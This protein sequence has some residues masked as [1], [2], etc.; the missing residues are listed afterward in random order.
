MSKHIHI[1]LVLLCLASGVQAQETPTDDGCMPPLEKLSTN[2]QHEWNDFLNAIC[3]D[4]KKQGPSGN[5]PALTF[6][7][8]NSERIVVGADYNLDDSAAS[9]A[10]EQYDWMRVMVMYDATKRLGDIFNTVANLGYH[11]VIHATFQPG[12][13][14]Q[15]YVY[16]NATLRHIMSLESPMSA[17]IYADAVARRKQ[18]PFPFDDGVTCTGVN[19]CN[20]LWTIHLHS[21]E[22]LD[23]EYDPYILCMAYC[24]G[25]VEE[26]E[27]MNYI[28]MD[29]TTARFVIT[30]VGLT[31]TFSFDFSP[32]QLLG[33]EPAIDI[34]LVGRRLAQTTAA[35]LPMQV[36]NGTWESCSYDQE[37]KMLAFTTL[38]DELTILNNQGHEGQYKIMILN[39][40]MMN[41]EQKEFLEGMAEV[42][43][44]MEFR[45]Q[46]RTTRRTSTVTI[47][48]D[49]LRVYLLE[50]E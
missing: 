15:Y 17:A 36:G 5:N 23:A 35:S 32:A 12:G 26:R 37:L 4:W 50:R 40:L 41:P 21:D 34:D 16:N 48:P 7:D 19:Y 10:A 18:V 8:L 44:G 49:E 42:G 9:H 45:M 46:S 1:I 38:T 13:T 43:L 6:K 22:P 33:D 25:I 24:A 2:E 29:G 3:K 28:G 14:T 30:A 31:D 47:T 11:V 27:F 39:T 20:H